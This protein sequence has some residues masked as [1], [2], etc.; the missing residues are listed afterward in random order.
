MFPLQTSV[1]WFQHESGNLLLFITIHNLYYNILLILEV[2][3]KSEG[4]EQ[5]ETSKI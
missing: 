1:A 2:N 3:L 5:E 4:R